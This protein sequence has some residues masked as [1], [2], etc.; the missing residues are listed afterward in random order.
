MRKMI[1]G[2]FSPA[3]SR[4]REKERRER[5]R[6]DAREWAK[7]RRSWEKNDDV[8]NGF[9]EFIVAAVS[10]GTSLPQLMD[11]VLDFTGYGGAVGSFEF[12]M[13]RHLPYG[14]NVGEREGDG[15]AIAGEF[16]SG[17]VQELFVVMFGAVA[18][19]AFEG[20]GF[21]DEG[22]FAGLERL[23]VDRFGE[24]DI[25]FALSRVKLDG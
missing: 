5:E 16:C 22:L 21:Y 11:R 18:R 7:T 3:A 25:Y 2:R 6:R 8:S 14:F 23:G 1:F 12:I 10:F 13:Y 4:D 20:P 9:I 17:D 19:C 24:G 15:L